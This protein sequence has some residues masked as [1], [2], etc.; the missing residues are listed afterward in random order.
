MTVFC[1]S[2][3]FDLFTPF[4]TNL[5]H[6]AIRSPD[7]CIILCSPTYPSSENFNLKQCTKTQLLAFLNKF[8]NLNIMLFVMYIECMGKL[9]TLNCDENTVKI[10][11]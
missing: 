4:H 8:N 11:L 7:A 2:F 1:K 10:I 3:V 6:V 9:V 5:R